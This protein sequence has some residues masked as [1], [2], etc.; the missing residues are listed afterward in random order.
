MPKKIARRTPRRSLELA[1]RD[2]V[3]LPAAWNAAVKQRQSDHGPH[4]LGH[5]Q[6]VAAGRCLNGAHYGERFIEDRF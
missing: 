4:K 3:N 5:C 6:S 2:I 1:T